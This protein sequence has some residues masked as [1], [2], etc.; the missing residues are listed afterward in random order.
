MAGDTLRERFRKTMHFEPVEK[1]PNFE[2]GY[3]TE[4]LPNWHEQGLPREIDTEAKAYAYF[5]IENSAGA[6]PVTTLLPAF[7]A[8]VIGS[9]ATHVLS[10]T[11][12]GATVETPKD[13][14]STIPRHLEFG[15]KDRKT[16]AEYLKR[17]DSESPGRIAE[18]LD[19]LAEQSRT[20]DQ[21][22]GLWIGSLIGVPRNW[23]GFEYLA[24]MVYDDPGLVDEICETLCR[25]ITTCIKPY[26]DKCSYDFAGGWEDICF[27]SGP[28][29]SPTMFEQFLAERYKRIA[30]MARGA[31]IDVIFTDCDGNINDVVP[32]WLAAGYNCMFP[33][34]VHGGSDPVALRQKYGKEILFLGGFDKMALLK[35]PKAIEDELK[36]IAPTVAEGGFIPHVDHRVP[37]N[38]TLENY[39]AYLKLKR[40]IINT[41]G[42]GPQY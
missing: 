37:A 4:T 32:I 22:W 26:L 42:P 17:L 14:H 30:D 10:R 1:I 33:V 12:E 5:G 16:W 19:E 7:K 28:L 20:S 3:W 29:L 18:N 9:T 41:G 39:K 23:I 15:L 24:L 21:P 13:G 38:V 11:G 31:G 36:R 6:G 40:E 8:E 2:F 27:N 35:G 34:E 25:L